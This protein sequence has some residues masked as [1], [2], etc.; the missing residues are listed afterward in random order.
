MKNQLEMLREPHARQAFS[1][2]EDINDT[3]SVRPFDKPRY[4]D[5]PSTSLRLCAEPKTPRRSLATAS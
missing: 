2:T 1:R 5:D 3:I 4:V